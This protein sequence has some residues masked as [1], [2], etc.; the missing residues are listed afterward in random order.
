MRGYENN[1][2]RLD[3]GDDRGSGRRRG[4]IFSSRDRFGIKKESIDIGTCGKE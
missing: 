4:S 2:T 3:L 1:L